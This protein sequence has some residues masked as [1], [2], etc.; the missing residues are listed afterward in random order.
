MNFPRKIIIGTRSSDLA[1]WQS[2]FIKSRI[3]AIAPDIYIELKHIKTKGDKFINTPLAKIGGKGLFTKELENALLS[4][5]INVAVHSLKDLETAVPEGLAIAAVTERH[6]RED[7]LIARTRG[8]TIDD[9]P[10]GGTVG[11]GSTRRRAQLLALRPDLTTED[12]RGN[13]PTRI[14]KFQESKW[15]AVI[16]ARAGVERLGL[17]QHI[18]SVIPRHVMIPAVGQGALG[19]EINSDNEALRR[20]LEKIDHRPTRICTTAERTFLAA[21]GGGC[22]YP[23]AA[24]ADLDGESIRIEGMVASVDGSEQYRD[25][26]DGP[27][28]DP[29]SLGRRLA[30]TLLDRG[31]DKI[32]GNL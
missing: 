12:L 2:N 22:Q 27:A 19:V 24:T 23:I 20:L 28:D 32:L 5:E 4:G 31:A 29:E 1:L 30:R 9:I 10:S 14:R 13:V 25:A 15:D 26:I 6:A 11:T 21:L 18:S 8:T 17:E 3:A 7:V 16:L